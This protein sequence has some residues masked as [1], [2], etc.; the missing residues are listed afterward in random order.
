MLLERD[1]KMG[2]R[3]ARGERRTRTELR[4]VP[5]PVT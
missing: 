4:G 3:A 2:E 1:E 5:G